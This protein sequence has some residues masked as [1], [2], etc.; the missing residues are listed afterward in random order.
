MVWF[1]SMDHSAHRIWK[2][3]NKVYHFRFMEGYNHAKTFFIIILLFCF[4]MN[5]FFF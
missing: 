2:V 5:F 3:H 4:V 1:Y